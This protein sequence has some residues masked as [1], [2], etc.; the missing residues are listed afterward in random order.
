MVLRGR[1]EKLPPPAWTRGSTVNEY[2]SCIW[3]AA[4][5]HIKWK[6]NFVEEVG[7]IRLVAREYQHGRSSPLRGSI[8]PLLLLV[9]VLIFILPTLVIYLHGI[10]P[11]VCDTHRGASAPC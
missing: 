2:H 3:G 6:E 5:G 10:L 9:S 11:I 1:K 4:H 8:W 7:N